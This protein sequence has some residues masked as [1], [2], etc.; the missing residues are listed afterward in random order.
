M[1]KILNWFK[2]KSVAYFI[3]IGTALLALIVAIVFLATY[4]NPDLATVM[5]NKAEGFVV[6]TIPVFLL[7][8]FAVQVAVL[9]VPQYRFLQFAPVTMFGLA[10]YKEIILIPDFFVGKAN[11]VEYNGGNFE[12]NLFFF[13]AVTLIVIASIIPCFMGFYKKDADGDAEF[14]LKG[15]MRIAKVGASAVIIIAAVLASSLVAGSLINKAPK[16][17]QGG[18]TSQSSAEPVKPAKDPITDEIR[19]AAEAV[20]YDYN[21]E[22]VIIKEQE[23]G[24]KYA[25][26]SDP[27]YYNPD[28]AGLSEG[29]K[30]RDGHNM[31]YYFEGI[32]S[33]GYHGGYGTYSA[34]LY[35]WD[36][37]LFTGTSNNDKFKGY[38]YNSSIDFGKDEEGNDIADCLNMETNKNNYTSIITDAVKGFY[39]RQGYV[40]LNPGWGDRSVV[41]SGYKYYPDVAMFIDTDG[42]EEFKVGEV[43]NRENLWAANKVIKNLTYTPIM[44]TGSVKWTYPDGMLDEN[45]KFAA[46]GTYQIQAEWSGFSTSVTITVKEAAQAE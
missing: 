27:G 6:D 37:G 15:T 28:L 13:I 7:A 9:L 2:N 40:H 38:W 17:Q 29:A 23:D 34:Y 30:T 32:F 14:P 44:D 46:A 24:Y 20:A 43:F 39:Q 45:N 11:G 26:N 3:A 19:A 10:F 41:V 35:L 25:D 36:D 1:E 5:G 16:K 33:E 42:V 4:R 12:L 21:P 22:E 8:G 18:T 31:V